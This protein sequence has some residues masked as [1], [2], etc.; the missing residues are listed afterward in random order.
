MPKFKEYNQGQMMLL[1]PDIRDIIPSNHICY[2]IIQI[3]VKIELGLTAIAHNFIKIANWVRI[4]SNRKQFDNLMRRRENTQT[5]HDLS[6][7]K[8]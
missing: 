8:K 3:W 2:V 4:D 5:K 1:P 6:L 7:L